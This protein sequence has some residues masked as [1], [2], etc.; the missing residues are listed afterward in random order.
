[1]RYFLTRGGTGAA[2]G[3]AGRSYDFWAV[4]VGVGSAGSGRVDGGFDGVWVGWMRGALSVATCGLGPVD[5]E[6]VTD[7]KSSDPSRHT[8]RGSHYKQNDAFGGTNNK[9]QKQKKT[10]TVLKI[11]I[12]IIMMMIIIIGIIINSQHTSNPC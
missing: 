1:M 9:R 12:I 3:V 7:S 10:E 11:I 8:L 2:A 6:P 4:G 5:V